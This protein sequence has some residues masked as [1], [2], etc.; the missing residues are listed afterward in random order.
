MTPLQHLGML[1][2]QVGRL[3]RERAEL[4]EVRSLQDRAALLLRETYLA[5]SN[6]ALLIREWDE[7][8]KAGHGRPRPAAC[9]APSLRR[10]N[11][12]VRRLPSRRRAPKINTLEPS[13]PRDPRVPDAAVLERIEDLRIV[14]H[15]HAAGERTFQAAVVEMAVWA[16]SRRR[17]ERHCTRPA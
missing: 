2:E 17:R 13:F 1:C 7:E 5:V 6:H 12:A 8:F 15:N 4:V 11:P 3:A 16:A 14:E 10:S 9:D